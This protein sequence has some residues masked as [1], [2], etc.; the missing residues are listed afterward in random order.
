MQKQGVEYLK[1]GNM[2]I[3]FNKENKSIEIKDGLKKQYY[4]L[5]FLMILNLV[6]ALLRLIGFN[7]FEYGLIE[8]I[9]L[10]VGIASISVLYFLYFKRSTRDQI[11]VVEIKRLKEKS[12]FGGN[13]LYL[14][15]KNG[16]L[17]DVTNMKNQS[18]F[19]ETKKMFEEF[20]IKR[21]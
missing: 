20:G 15:L 16:K 3:K 12:F 19:V 5:K 14:E 21:S 18:D 9:W 2:K 10:L 1:K 13:R 11:K 4:F 6:N 17:R 7:P 8:A